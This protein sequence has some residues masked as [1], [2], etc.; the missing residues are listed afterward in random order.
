MTAQSDLFIHLYEPEASF[1]TSFLFYDP[2]SNNVG[3]L[4]NGR[5]IGVQ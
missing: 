4:Y 2:P 3:L 1:Y 5:G